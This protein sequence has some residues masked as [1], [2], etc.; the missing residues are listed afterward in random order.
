[1][2]LDSIWTWVGFNAAL[3][4]LLFLDLVILTRRDHVV[5]MAEAGWTGWTGKPVV[6]GAA[7]GGGGGGGQVDCQIRRT[8]RWRHAHRVRGKLSLTRRNGLH[9]RGPR[10]LGPS[11]WL[12]PVRPPD[13]RARR[14][15]VRSGRGAHTNSIEAVRA[16]RERSIH[17]TWRDVR[18][19]RLGRY[20]NEARF[21]LNEGDCG[22]D[23]IDRMTHFTKGV[24]GKRLRYR[25]LAA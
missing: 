23:A 25:D 3:A 2:L 4:A 21:L 19:K 10:L 5:G 7:A 9:G 1:M 18:P 24:G 17:G 6:S 22:V 16:V 13:H 14:R 20:V 11:E 12:Q 8:R 15:G